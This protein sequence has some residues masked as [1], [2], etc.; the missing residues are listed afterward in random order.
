MAHY[1]ATIDSPCGPA[2]T[3]DYL[4]TFSNAEQWD[5]GVL[6]GE[7]LDSG[8]VRVGTR[9]RLVVPFLG[10]R[11]PLTY[12]V[13][14][15]SPAGMIALEAVSGLL[16]LVEWIEVAAEGDGATV[17]YDA[18]VRLRGPL[19]LLDPML[20]RGFG[21]VGDRAAVGLA[22]A[23]AGRPQGVVGGPEAVAGGPEGVAGDP[24]GVVGGPEGVVGGFEAAG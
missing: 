10:R 16:R 4:A 19:R 1:H 12:V 2:E 17:S 11:L 18:D 23:L 7:Q 8:P 3:F 15:Y 21:A 13:T 24:E 9:F 14:R 6:S 22:A 20:Q 5:P